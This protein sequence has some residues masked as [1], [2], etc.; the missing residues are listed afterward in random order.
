[1]KFKIWLETQAI[2]NMSYSKKYIG[3]YITPALAQKIHNFHIPGWRNNPEFLTRLKY[4]IDQD[5]DEYIASK[6]QDFEKAVIKIAMDVGHR[7]QQAQFKKKK[8]E[9]NP[10]LHTKADEYERCWSGDKFERIVCG[11]NQRF[12]K[13][14]M[15]AYPLKEEINNDPELRGY[16]G[17]HCGDADEWLDWL[18]DDGYCDGDIYIYEITIP[19][20]PAF[21]QVDDNNSGGY[22]GDHA[23]KQ[24]P[25]A[26]IIFSE[27]K[28]I[29][30]QYIKLTKMIK[31]ADYWKDRK[32]R[33]RRQY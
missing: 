27:L 12:E 19:E 22:G 32:K 28:L 2:N 23:S 17:I 5:G 6:P 18:I 14:G 21:Y 26:Q 7:Q 4:L 33:D 3:D 10:N 9:D 29:P 8:E 15:P 24:V 1:M 11:K 20:S 31:D 30:A 13:T 25:S 16:F